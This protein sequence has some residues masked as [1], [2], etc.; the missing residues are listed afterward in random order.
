MTITSAAA[1]LGQDTEGLFEVAGGDFGVMVKEHSGGL[2]P[3]HAGLGQMVALHGQEDLQALQHVVG[4]GVG[5][6]TDEDALLV[7]LEHR[8]AAHGVE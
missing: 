4:V 5:A 8:G 6:Q 3:A 2:P 7:H 1:P